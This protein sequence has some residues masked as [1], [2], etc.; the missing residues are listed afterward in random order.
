M[1]SRGRKSSAPGCMTNDVPLHGVVI[2]QA[3]ERR[4]PMRQGLW[5][6]RTADEAT[7]SLSCHAEVSAPPCAHYGRALVGEALPKKSGV[8]GASCRKCETLGCS[9]W[10][11]GRRV[12]CRLHPFK[13]ARDLD[14]GG[15]DLRRELVIDGVRLARIGPWIHSQLDVAML[16]Q[17]P[18]GVRVSLPL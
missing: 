1:W 3:G 7:A 14:G 10:G 2:L 11:C 17:L 8:K 13:Q 6:A 16:P 12:G 5:R 4:K 18:E 9:S 15:N